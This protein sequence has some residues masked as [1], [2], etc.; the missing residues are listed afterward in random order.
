M[1]KNIKKMVSVVAITCMIANVSLA[2]AYETKGGK[3]GKTSVTCSI[4]RQ[5]GS[6]TYSQAYLKISVEWSARNK[7]EKLGI[8]NINIVKKDGGGEMGVSKSASNA[9]TVSYAGEHYKPGSIKRI[10]AKFYVTS[11]NFGN[12]SV[13]LSE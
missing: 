11:S 13:N 8:K 12:F 3:L 5:G 10:S 9:Y 1:K 4:S 6:T 2:G 7:V